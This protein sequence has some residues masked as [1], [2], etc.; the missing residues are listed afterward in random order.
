MGYSAEKRYNLPQ[1]FATM[2]EGV[3]LKRRWVVSSR[4]ALADFLELV[5]PAYLPKEQRIGG[6]HQSKNDAAAL[7]CPIVSAPASREAAMTFLRSLSPEELDEL[8]PELRGLIGK[9]KR[10]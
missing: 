6:N 9:P 2:L 5:D 8:A 3:S 4:K 1:L 7:R 10:P